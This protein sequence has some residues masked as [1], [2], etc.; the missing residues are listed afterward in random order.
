MQL[1]INNKYQ[2]IVD[3]VRNLMRD[4]RSMK[5]RYKLAVHTST[6]PEIDNETRWGSQLRIL[7]SFSKLYDVLS[8]CGFVEKTIDLIPTVATKNK[9]DILISILKDI[10]IGHEDEADTFV[11]SAEDIGDVLYE[12]LQRYRR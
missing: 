7:K 5:N 3:T 12:I 2:D 9:V 6:V 11:F 8:L 4:L 10:E 1:L